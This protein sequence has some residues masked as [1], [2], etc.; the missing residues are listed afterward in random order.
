MKTNTKTFY[1]QNETRICLHM[2][3][4]NLIVWLIASYR[5]FIPILRSKVS[6]SLDTKIYE[7]GLSSLEIAQFVSKVNEELICPAIGDG[8]GALAVETMFS[9][10]TIGELA[11]HVEG[12]LESFSILPGSTKENMEE[13]ENVDADILRLKPIKNCKN[14]FPL[15]FSQRESVVW[16]SM[17]RNSEEAASA[18]NITSF[19]ILTSSNIRD[20]SL[21]VKHMFEAIAMR[22]EPLLPAI[23]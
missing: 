18:T 8:D 20:I 2:A 15:L 6:F 11:Q 17:T 16:S 22:H 10:D 21:E 7:L 5:L 14:G 23:S 3:R 12:R 9:L 13:V 4:E 1:G 19:C